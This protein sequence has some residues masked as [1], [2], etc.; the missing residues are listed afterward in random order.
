MIPLIT[1]LIAIAIIALISSL[2]CHAFIKRHRPANIASVIY[3]LLIFHGLAY[4]EAGYM[5][6][7]WIISSLIIVG[8]TLPISLITGTYLQ[9][10]RRLKAR[11]KAQD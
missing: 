4:L 10:K 7:Y 11:Q 6:P 5:D 1:S 8:I 2:F 3:T 9:E